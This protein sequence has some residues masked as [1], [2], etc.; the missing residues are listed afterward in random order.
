MHLL[1][2]FLKT[3][4]VLN[5]RNRSSVSGTVQAATRLSAYSNNLPNSAFMAISDIFVAIILFQE[6]APLEGTVVP[7]SGKA[8]K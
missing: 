2:L 4:R 8:L 6:R 1:V 7:Y 5:L 3:N